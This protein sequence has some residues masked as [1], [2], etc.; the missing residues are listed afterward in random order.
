MWYDATT[1][2]VVGR[3]R[4]AMF[5]HSFSTAVR[6]ESHKPEDTHTYRGH[7]IR[8]LGQIYRAVAWQTMPVPRV[9]VALHRTLCA[10]GGDS[11]LIP[12]SKAHRKSRYAVKSARPSARRGPEGRRSHERH[13]RRLDK[14]LGTGCL[15]AVVNP[16]SKACPRIDTLSSPH[17]APPGGVRAI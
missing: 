1:A 3:E 5:R 8:N 12:T 17:V 13:Q 10:T 16:N 9:Y 4:F 15:H 14:Q 6:K 11:V 2:N 7:Y